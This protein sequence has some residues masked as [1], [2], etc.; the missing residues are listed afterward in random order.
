MIFATNDLLSKWGFGDGDMLDDLLIDFGGYD[1]TDLTWF[2]KSDDV[3]P[4][5]GFEHMVLI[6]AVCAY[7]VP[8]IDQRVEVFVVGTIHNPIRAHRVDGTLVASY[9]NEDGVTLTPETVEVEDAT[10]LALARALCVPK[11]LR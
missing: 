10:I 9:D 4:F 5:H 6:A 11:D 3:G 2:T 8:K 1:Y 7:V